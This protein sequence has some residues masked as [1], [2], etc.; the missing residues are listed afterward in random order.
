MHT[1]YINVLFNYSVFDM[2][3]ISKCLSSGRLVHAVLWYFSQAHPTID[4]TAYM[5]AL[6]K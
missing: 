6:K 2:F 1:F 5:D 3:R 4:Q